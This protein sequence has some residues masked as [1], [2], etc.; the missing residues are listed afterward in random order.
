MNY[1]NK[2]EAAHL[3]GNAP[4]LSPDP[5][6]SHPRIANNPMKLP[7]ILRGRLLG[8]VND[9]VKDLDTCFY[10]S[11]V[12]VSQA[13]TSSSG[14][15]KRIFHADPILFLPFPF[16]FPFPSFSFGGVMVYKFQTCIFVFLRVYFSRQPYHSY[17]FLFVYHNTIPKFNHVWAQYKI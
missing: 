10:F 12:S 5:R 4:Q 2:P 7:V 9:C 13:K 17:L 6:G 14:N 8:L 16:P 11:S 1:W 15:G 3:R